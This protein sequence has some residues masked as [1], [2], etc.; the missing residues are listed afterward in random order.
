MVSVSVLPKYVENRQEYTNVTLKFYS[1]E[2]KKYKTYICPA[3]GQVRT[4]T[5]T[6]DKGI[7]GVEWSGTNNDVIHMSFVFGK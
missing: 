7:C 3:D 2:T 4:F 6:C 5:F 1:K